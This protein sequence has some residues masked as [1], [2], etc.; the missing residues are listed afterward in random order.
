MAT[1][2]HSWLT[3]EGVPFREDRFTAA[4]L[5]ALAAYGVGD[6][7][8]TIGLVWFSPLHVEANPVIAGAIGLFGGGGFLGLK[9]LVFYAALGVSLWG[10]LPD[11]DAVLF[12]G[13]PLVL[14]GFGLLTTA[15][16][17]SLLL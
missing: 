13:P 11:E 7:V 17:V 2:D 8:T 16:N 10:G 3:F 4:W 14:M 1:A 9:L 12:Y 5:L 15:I 6:V